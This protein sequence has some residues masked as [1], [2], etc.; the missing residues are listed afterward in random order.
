MRKLDVIRVPPF[1]MAHTGQIW[2]SACTSARATRRRGRGRAAY[3]E[4]HRDLGQ[5]ASGADSRRT[6]RTFTSTPCAG[7]FNLRRQHD[8][9][10]AG[11]TGQA[12][13]QSSRDRMPAPDSLGLQ[14]VVGGG[15][16]VPAS[17]FMAKRRPSSWS[18]GLK[19]RLAWGFAPYRRDVMDGESSRDREGIFVSRC[20]FH[21]PV[22]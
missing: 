19:V 6:A 11:A 17:W 13:Q 9:R 21:E 20:A 14:R 12:G 2:S 5:A 10:S 1:N 22:H 3:H 15:R 8:H 4:F 16:C 7:C 18:R